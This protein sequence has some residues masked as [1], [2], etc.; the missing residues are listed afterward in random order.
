MT[1]WTFILLMPKT[2]MVCHPRIAIITFD[3]RVTKF[4]NFHIYNISL[5]IWTEVRGARTTE[6]LLISTLKTFFG[7]SDHKFANKALMLATAHF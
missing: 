3:H 1:L 4:I 5:A 6:K 7:K 2:N